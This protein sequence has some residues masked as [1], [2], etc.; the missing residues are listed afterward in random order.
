MGNYDVEINN[1][2]LNND[3]INMSER[4]L[5]YINTSN[6][7]IA[8][9]YNKML[10]TL[11]KQKYFV[12]T[13]T[14]PKHIKTTIDFNKMYFLEEY[15]HLYHCYAFTENSFKV[16]RYYYSTGKVEKHEYGS[17]TI[18]SEADFVSRAIDSLI[19]VDDYEFEYSC[20]EGISRNGYSCYEIIANRTFQT[21]SMAYTM[22]FYIDMNTYK[23]IEI[24]DIYCSSEGESTSTNS[25]FEYS[26][27]EFEIPKEAQ[28]FL[29][30]Y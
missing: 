10:D 8:N 23:L 25:Y 6:E 20:T 17:N 13:S 12:K 15:E 11:G 22:K 24:E 28:E 19:P 1:K 7:N 18:D 26:N 21:D 27:S 2:N 3:Y 9:I 16:Y 5:S 14:N 4:Y 29:K 30:I